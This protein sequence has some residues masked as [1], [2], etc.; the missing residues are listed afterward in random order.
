MAL[1]PNPTSGSTDPTPDPNA[2]WVAEYLQH[3]RVEKRLA[4]RTQTL[5]TEHLND[6]LARCTAAG[7]GLEAI[8]PAHVRRWVAQLRSS[9][10]NPRGIAL[11]LSCW[12]GLYTWLVR[13]G[14]VN[15]HPVVG[16]RAPKAPK[17]L[18]KALGVE[19]AVRLADGPPPHTETEDDAALR[20][21]D[22]CM[23]ELLYGSGLRISELLGLDV[24]P[25]DASAGWVDAESAEVHVLGKGGKRRT[26]PVGRPALE[27][28]AQW[29]VLRA[30]WLTALPGVLPLFIGR[31]GQRLTP[32]AARLRLSRLSLKAGLTTPVHPHMLRH[33]FAS[34]LLQSSSDL[35]A[36]QELLGHANIAT[37][38]VYTRLDFQHLA[39][40]Y[41]AAHPRAKKSVPD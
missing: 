17:P 22:R 31:R 25:G 23:V 19:D 34:H 2:A 35:R 28:L 7:V 18:P 16:V 10:R 1:E 33:S 8:Q 36:V 12:R 41:E 24:R 29:L 6:L 13:Q 37:T 9:G 3:V 39:K 15:H 11:V 5:Y 30:D 26:V 38:Q 21:R 14:K 20:A 40:V 4:Q 32:Q 27:A